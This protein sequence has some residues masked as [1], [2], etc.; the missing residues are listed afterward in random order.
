M[1]T[2]QVSKLKARL[3]Q[4]VEAAKHGQEVIITDR[5]RPVAVLRPLE[6]PL[7]DAA[8]LNSLV[9]LGFMRPAFK[10]LTDSVSSASIR[11]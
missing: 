5:N 4:F 3:S 7:R 10:P 2:V 1:P 11:S 6:R 8:T 9:S